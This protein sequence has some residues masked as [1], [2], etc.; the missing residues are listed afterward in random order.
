MFLKT[1]YDYHLYIRR[2]KNIR[3]LKNLLQNDVSILNMNCFGG[4]IY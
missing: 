4:R 3:K 1:V 2:L